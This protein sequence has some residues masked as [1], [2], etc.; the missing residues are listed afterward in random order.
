MQ[1]WHTPIYRVLVLAILAAL[2][3]A[4]L[5]PVSA[6]GTPEPLSETYP[7]YQ[8]EA[9]ELALSYLQS[10]QQPDG[11]INGFGSG[12]NPG[13]TA[14]ALLLLNAVGYPPSALVTENGST[15]LDYLAQRTP[16]YLYAQ[17]VVAEDNLFPAPAGLVLAAVAAAGEDPTNFA[18]IDLISALTTT[19]KPSGAYSTTAGFGFFYGDADAINQSLA[20]FGLVAAGQ[21][22]PEA[23]TD[24]LIAAQEP[25]GSWD[26]GDVDITCYSLLALLGS[27]NV[28]PTDPAIQRAIAFL[29]AAQNANTALWNSGTT[30]AEPANSTGWVINALSAA[31][32][33]P[34]TASWTTGGT[35][36][37]AA[38]LNLQDAEGRIAG[39]REFANAHATIE[40]LYGLTGQPLYWTRPLR[41]AWALAWLAEQQQPNGSW[42]NDPATT[43]DVLVAFATAGSDPA[44]VSRSGNTPLT[45]LAAAATDYTRD[46]DTLV[47]EQIGR[48]LVGVVAAGGDPT[49]FGADSLNLVAD[50]Q[51]TVQP[52]GAYSSTVNLATPTTQ[53]WAVL[54]LAAAG[55]AIPPEAITW[56][57]GQQQTGGSWGSAATT[58]LVLQALVAAGVP[59]DDAAITA[60]IT[61]L[62]ES[63]ISTGGW[64]AAGG[65]SSSATAAAVQGLLA[66]D[67]NLSSAEWRKQNRTPLGVLGSYQK[68]DGPFVLNWDYS[69]GGTLAADNVA[70]T[71]Q[72]VPALL[73]V[74]APYTT[75]DP[76]TLAP[77]TALPRGPEPDR[78]VAA[79]PFAT[80]GEGG[81]I[82]VI[83]PFGSDLNGNGTLVLEWRTADTSFTSLATTRE[84]GF[85][86]ATIAQAAIGSTPPDGLQFRATFR[87]PDG[88][89]QGS[90]ITNEGTTTGQLQRV[91]LPLVV[92][93]IGEG[94]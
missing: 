88:V 5:P 44:S 43:L 31:G 17:G 70:A 42:A 92:R 40:G 18:G 22:V 38:L 69:A 94:R 14:R 60:G 48:L 80:F 65:F 47:P 89:Q 13:S 91:F 28:S 66:A 41:V 50:L 24:W 33:L 59:T 11:G 19:L 72:A 57:T 6:Q 87:D 63:Q 35:N 51:S 52:T 16:A 58:G 39:T 2:F 85:Y 81:E 71:A 61:F 7:F 29:K 53:A 21:P 83:V 86:R 34:T 82:M 78:T 74:V 54:G 49:T 36:P 73:G 26:F 8:D 64:G 90:S 12:A 37:V 1:R 46:D 93:V 79:E 55:A 20:I 27:G 32:Y 84:V 10:Q 45:Y 30:R 77:F 25:Q 15:L 62:R 76:A 23:A 75:I 3:L 68:P 9:I 67:V 4:S 56:L